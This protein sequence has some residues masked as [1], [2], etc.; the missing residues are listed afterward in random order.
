MYFLPL[1]HF[2]LFFFFI[3][4]TQQAHPTQFF[5]PSS[6]FPPILFYIYRGLFSILIFRLFHTI[7]NFVRLCT[8]SSTSQPMTKAGFDI[9]LFLYHFF[10]F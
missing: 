5:F 7:T 2:S 8:P 6:F 10:F 1:H 3:L 4:Y 9:R